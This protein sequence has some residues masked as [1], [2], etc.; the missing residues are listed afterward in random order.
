MTDAIDLSQDK[1]DVV[2]GMKRWGGG[3]VK[4]LSHTLALADQENTTA[5]KKAF[6][7]YWKKYGNMYRKYGD[8][9]IWP[10]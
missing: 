1:Y 10:E 5:I 2:Q 8:P 6:P 9:T 3:F 4:S 7:K